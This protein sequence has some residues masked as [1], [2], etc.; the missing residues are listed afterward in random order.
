MFKFKLGLLTIIAVAIIGCSTDNSSKKSQPVVVEKKCIYK[1]SVDSS[2]MVWTGFKFN[3]RVGVKGEFDSIYISGNK[4]SESPMGCIEGLQ[5]EI[6]TSS[7]NTKDAGRDKKVHEIFFGTFNTSKIS[8][9]IDSVNGMK[10]ILSLNLNE[11]NIKKEIV[12]ELSDRV[13][14]SKFNINV[15]DW[16]GLDAITA[17]NKACE[18]KHTGN[19][20]ESVLWPDVDIL[21]RTSLEKNCE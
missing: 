8:G 4:L 21:L 1:V 20:K 14:E 6:P 17:L 16:N 7:V 10:A 12:F 11:V 15:K 19:N 18:E 2:L 13:L 9:S 3:D 5:F